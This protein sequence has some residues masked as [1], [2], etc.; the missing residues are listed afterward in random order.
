MYTWIQIQ[1]KTFS[2][3]TLIVWYFPSS[4]IVRCTILIYELN[5]IG[6]NSLVDD[7]NNDDGG[8]QNQRYKTFEL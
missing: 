5:W 6:N 1:N 2:V 3:G 7:D 8:Q 4:S